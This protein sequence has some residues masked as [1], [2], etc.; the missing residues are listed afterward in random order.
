MYKVSVFKVVKGR[1]LNRKGTYIEH[2]FAVV[3]VFAKLF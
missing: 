2:A 1:L 3:L